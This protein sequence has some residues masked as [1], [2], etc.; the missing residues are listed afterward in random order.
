MTTTDKIK[1]TLTNALHPKFIQVLDDSQAHAGH[2]GAKS[3][4]GHYY[5]TII[6]DEFNN[7]S[8]IQRHQVVYNALGDMMK[9]EIHALSIKAHTP[10]EQPQQQEI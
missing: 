10:E 9:S 4:G 8:R 6:C 3:G 2:E 1:D 5:L 7:K